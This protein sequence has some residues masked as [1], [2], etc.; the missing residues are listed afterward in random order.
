[1]HDAHLAPV[2]D[3]LRE[4]PTEVRTPATSLVADRKQRCLRLVISK[5]GKNQCESEQAPGYDLCPHHM[6]E[7]VRD[8][9]EI[10]AEAAREYAGMVTRSL[11]EAGP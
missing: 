1:V 8:Y 5:R 9:S 11:G 10:A 4:Q 7:A 3:P 6:A 2:P